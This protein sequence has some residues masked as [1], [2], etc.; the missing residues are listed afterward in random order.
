MHSFIK[1]GS[2]TLLATAGLFAL[3]IPAHAAVVCHGFVGTCVSTNWMINEPGDGSVEISPA[4]AKL[5]SNNSGGGSTFVTMELNRTA[6]AKGTVSF[7]YDYTT[8]DRDGSPFDPFGY[9]L[10]G[11]FNQIIPPPFVAQ[12]ESATGNI[13]FGVKHGDTFGFYTQATDGILGE[14]ITSITDFK[15]TEVPGP[16]PIFGVAATFAYSRKMRK[17]SKNNL[18]PEVSP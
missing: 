7:K 1:A 13:T 3:S 18:Q 9:I 15:Y 2:S 17:R 12:G 4:E 5:T 16:L 10:N 11:A 14:A 6:Q 8:N